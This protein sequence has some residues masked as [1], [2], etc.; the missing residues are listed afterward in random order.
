MAQQKNI[1]DPL[2]LDEAMSSSEAFIIKYKNKFLIAIAAVVVVVCA[3]VGYKTYISEPREAKANDAIFAGQ[4]YFAND[5]FEQALNGDSLGYKGFIAIAK[6][7]SG[8]KAGNLANAYAGICMAQLGNYEEA[9]KYLDSFSASD[10][11][12]SPAVKAAMG[13]CYIETGKLEKG[14]SLLI[15]AANEAD[16]QALSPIYLVQAGQVLEKLGKNA[17]AV[18]VYTTV[19]EKYFN[20]YQAMEIDKYIERASI[21]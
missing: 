13:N 17:E 3:I 8:T 1:Q 16:S 19:K 9:I 6:E 7:F 15:D 12:V 18:K 14:A 10:A 4:Q 20:S 2:N 11:L 21:K 5:L